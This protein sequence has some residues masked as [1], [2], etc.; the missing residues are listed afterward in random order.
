MS[1]DMVFVIETLIKCLLI[2]AIFAALAGFATF[3]ERKVL[4]WFHVRTGPMMVGPGGIL[5]IVPD[6][7]KLF[8]KEDIIPYN[9]NKIIFKI[10]PIIS[11]ICA[12][13]GF[14]SVPLFPE[15]NIFGLTIRPIIADINIGLLFVM[16]MSSLCAYAIFLGGMSSNNKWSLIGGAR[17]VVGF[18]SYESISALSLLSIVLIVG[19]LSIIDINNY[20]SGGIFSWF[21]FKQPLA[22]VLFVIALFVETNRTPLCLTENDTELVAG[23]GTEYSGLRWGMFFIGEYAS[24]FLGS[25]LV[26]LIFLGGFNSLSFF[27]LFSIH[28]SIM[29]IMKICFSFFLYFWARGTYPHLRADQLMRTCY[30]ILLPLAFLNLLI[31]AFC[32]L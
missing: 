27:G 21:I 22:F 9:S 1:G 3:L 17:A 5:Q 6:M 26:S 11:A 2:I 15:F 24:M 8:T 23:Y 20:Q 12:F 10:A 4:A 14:C 28:G 18:I 29:M 32:V 25:I 13:M 7:I 30:L 31:T 19:S 16:G